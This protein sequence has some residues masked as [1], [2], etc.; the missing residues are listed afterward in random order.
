MKRLSI[1]VKL[2][3]CFACVALVAGGLF[4][5]LGTSTIYDA[6]LTEAKNRTST[7]LS[8][9]QGIYEMKISSLA[10]I[11][12]LRS[13]NPVVVGAIQGQG[14]DPEFWALL[15]NYGLDFAGIV[16]A[17]GKVLA[18]MT[19]G[20]I[21]VE[22]SNPMV[23]RVL[24]NKSAMAGTMELRAGYIEQEDKALL[25]RLT[26]V[27]GKL[28]P[29]I[30]VVVAVPIMQ[31]QEMLGVL[32]GG[33]L[34]NHN[35]NLVNEILN[36]IF[37]DAT[38]EGKPIGTFTIFGKDTRIATNVVNAEGKRAVGTQ[39]GATVIKTVLTDGQNWLDRAQV[40]GNWYVTAY[41]PLLDVDKNR[42]GMLYVGVLEDSFAEVR[43][44]ASR[45]FMM[46][47]IGV[48]VLT[49]LGGVWY[50]RRLS[51]GINNTVICMT[52]VARG[53]GDLT[54]R[55]PEDRYDELGRLSSEFNYFIDQLHQ[56]ISSISQLAARLGSSSSEIREQNLNLN[57]RTG[58]QAASIENIASALEELAGSIKGTAQHSQQAA[59]LAA[60]SSTIATQGGQALHA[61]VS[62]MQAVTESSQ[63]IGNIISVVNEIAFQTNLL[64]LNAAVEAARAGEAGKGFAVVAGEVRNLAG[65]SAE[66]AKEI[67]DLISDSMQKVAQGNEQVARSGDILDK[68]IKNV[69]EVAKTIDEINASSQEQASAI[70]EVNLAVNRMDQAVQENVTQVTSVAATSD[71]LNAMS[72]ELQK[73]V[74]RFQL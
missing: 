2:V 72:G 65:R 28:D 12:E 23:A 19:S 13:V 3:L 64:A 54:C 59:S 37:S 24:Q 18:R 69:Q 47:S 51:K 60:S 8:A 29:A 9:A 49:I 14:L 11:M 5:Y 55:L 6:L 22:N 32:Y 74:G 71:E 44:N 36:T 45:I 26:S 33:L 50:S 42:I 40:V 57:E 15:K 70:Q 35:Y 31:G 66:A 46:A 1:A 41:R 43:D 61:T 68:I 53:D 67:Q 30:S 17:N 10:Q 25:E 27:A 58:Q 7:N 56:I 52:D 34:L 62:A 38:F 20:A 73:L 4:L 48:V 39:A 63:R 16:D 21:N